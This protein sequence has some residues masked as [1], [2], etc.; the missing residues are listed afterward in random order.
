MEEKVQEREE[1]KQGEK[2]QNSEK[3]NT[4]HNGAEIQEKQRE[5]QEESK[6]GINKNLEEQRK[7]QEKFKQVKE[8]PKKIKEEKRKMGEKNKKRKILP[9][10]ITAIMIIIIGIIIS[11]V[12][13]LANINKDTIVSGVKIEGIEVSGLTA[14]EA[15]GKIESIYK[16]KLETEIPVQYNEYETTINANL[17]ETQ[18]NVE[19]PIKKAVNI[20]KEGN[21][22]TNNYNILFALMGKQNI[23]VEMQINEEASKKIIEDI[24]TN[25]P[26]VVI[27]S[28]YYIEN[29][30]LIITKG[31]AGVKID[32]E[33]MLNEVKEKLDNPEKIVD[34]INI[35]VTEVK[36]TEI[37]IDKIHEE[38]YKEVQDAYYTQ[39]PFEIHPEVEGIDF[40]VEEAKKALEEDKEEYE[41]SLKITK[42]K[43]TTNQIGTEAFPDQLATFKTN[44]DGGDKDRTTNLQIACNKI[45]GKVVMPNETFSYNK[46]LGARTAAAGYKNA[47]VYEAGQVVDGIGGGICQIS[48]TLYNTVLRANLEIVER[49]NHQFVTSYVEAGMDA[50]VVYGMTDFKFKNTR[51]YPVKIIASAKNGV[52][53]VSLYGIKESE[54]YTFSFRTVTV[55]TIP[56]STKYVDDPTLVVGTEKVKQKGANGKKTETYMTKMLNGKII[57]TKIISRDIYDAMQRIVL[58]GTKG[59]TN[60]TT[61]T[62]TNNTTKAETTNTNNGTTNNKETNNK[63]TNSGTTNKQQ[64]TPSTEKQKTDAT[65]TNNNKTTQSTQKSDSTK[66]N[67]KAE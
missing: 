51:K 33:K 44:Y 49:K 56:T 59:A 48:T 11:T 16:E 57:E 36:P 23:K 17:L 13:A 37:D 55:S 7:A 30:K 64:T 31:Q 22:F 63:E 39:N 46:T 28:T 66:T 42:P 41:I 1:Q 38:V 32:T 3:Q 54:E 52:A 8:K 61:K 35:P 26:G 53:T 6:K 29:D 47:K 20:G 10:I 40:D 21:I 14:E 4:E 58:R 2:A 43:V 18:Y 5:T 24:G 34:Y 45:N 65:P 62:E 50:T 15:K 25:L 60:T 27:E 67:E 19:K 9:I 12:F